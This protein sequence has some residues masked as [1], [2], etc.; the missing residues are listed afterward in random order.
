MRVVVVSARCPLPTGKG[1]Q[2]RAYGFIMHLRREHQV[3]VVTSGEAGSYVKPPRA[4]W[5]TSSPWKVT[6]SE[7]PGKARAA[8]AFSR[9]PNAPE[10]RSSCATKLRARKENPDSRLGSVRFKGIL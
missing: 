4:L 7:H 9:M 1:D 5:A 2:V 8:M 6:A 3:T 10:N